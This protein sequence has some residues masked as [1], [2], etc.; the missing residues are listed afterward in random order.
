[1]RRTLPLAQRVAGLVLA[2]VG[3][4]LVVGAAAMVSPPLGL[5]TAGA[6]LIYVARSLSE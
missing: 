1:M 6:C 4:G 3:A 5:A 2:V